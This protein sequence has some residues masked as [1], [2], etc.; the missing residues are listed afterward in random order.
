MNHKQVCLKNFLIRCCYWYYVQANPII[1]D[2]EFDQEFKRLQQMEAES[3][4]ADSDSP[5][6]MVWGDCEAQYPDWAKTKASKETYELLK[7]IEKPI[8]KRPRLVK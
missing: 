2:Y 8:P 4:E 1:S 5:T 6:Q 7:S 3:G